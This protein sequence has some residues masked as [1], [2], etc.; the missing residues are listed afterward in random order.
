MSDD[1]G[2]RRVGGVTVLDVVLDALVVVQ[3]TLLTVALVVMGIA[4]RGYAETTWGGVLRPITVAIAGFLGTTMAAQLPL[5]TAWYLTL[6]SAFWTVSVAAVAVATVRLN[7][8][9]WGVAS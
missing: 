8:M 7:R 3:S 5:P 1:A 9:T 4:A 2:S 6:S